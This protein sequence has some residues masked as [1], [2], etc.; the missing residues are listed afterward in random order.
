VEKDCARAILPSFLGFR[1]RRL[2]SPDS[3]PIDAKNDTEGNA[4]EALWRRIAR[5]PPNKPGYSPGYDHGDQATEQVLD[6]AAPSFI[7]H[8]SI[9]L[10][11]ARIFAGGRR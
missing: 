4:V 6:G 7:A 9:L 5:K 10:W 2:S 11:C 3:L 8:F 1:E